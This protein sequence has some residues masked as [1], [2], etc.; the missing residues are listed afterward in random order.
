[1]DQL[2]VQLEWNGPGT[3][4]ELIARMFQRIPA[5]CAIKIETVPA[6]IRYSAVIEATPARLPVIGA[7]AL[8]QMIEG[9]D[10]GAHAFTPRAIN[11]A[12]VLKRYRVRRGLFSSAFVRPQVLPY[13]E[14][15]RRYGDALIERLIAIE[16]APRASA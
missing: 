10:R 4:V 8:S 3:P 9:L 7:S 5:F 6:G 12:F 11:K 1:M 16:D 14:H 15:H 2:V 13:D